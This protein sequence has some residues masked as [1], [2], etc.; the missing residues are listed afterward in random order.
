MILS[1]SLCF[2]DLFSPWKCFIP[3]R[4]M[5]SISSGGFNYFHLCFNYI[6]FLVRKRI[7]QFQNYSTT[8]TFFSLEN[9]K[10]LEGRCVAYPV[11]V[12]SFLIRYMLFGLRDVYDTY[13]ITILRWP[14]FSL[15]NV[16]SPEGRCVAYPVGVKLLLLIHNLS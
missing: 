16:L 4:E 1:K 8:V 3:R 7:S 2:G 13:K 15:E 9:V 10:S 12:L 5:R 14:F 11:G 6:T